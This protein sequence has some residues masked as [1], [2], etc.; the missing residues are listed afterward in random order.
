M[1]ILTLDSIVAAVNDL[2]A[3][4]AVVSRVMQLTDDPN[5]T[6]QDVSSVLNQDQAITAR[7]LRLANSAYY[8]YTRRINTVAD[9]IIFLG[10]KT[11]RS[12]VLAASVSDILNQEIEAMLWN[13]ENCGDIRKPVP[14][15]P[16]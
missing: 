16:A 12:I 13:M 8:G 4:P 2:P 5:A 6:A 15:P 3:L 14:W 9:A 10:F 1:G 7:V 11:I